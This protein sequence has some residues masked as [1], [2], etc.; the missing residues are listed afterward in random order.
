VLDDPQNKASKIRTK[1]Q[2]ISSIVGYKPQT[3]VS[4]EYIE[5]L[6]DWKTAWDHIHFRGFLNVKMSMQF[7]WQGCDSILAAPLVLDLARLALLAQRRGEVGLLR[8]L[9]C[10]FKSPMGVD[11][12]DFFKQFAM[13]QEYVESLAR[14]PLALVGR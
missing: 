4:I 11:E 10:F 8:H 3:H 2:V 7:T 9:A 1:D 12:H 5:S 6:D 14:R 13:L